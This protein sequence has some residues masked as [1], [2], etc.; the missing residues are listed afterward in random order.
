MKNLWGEPYHITLGIKNEKCKILKLMK[1]LGIQQFK[2]KDI[3]GIN[4]GLV[5]H[6]VELPLNEIKRIPKERVNKI[7]KLTKGSAAWI[8]SEGCDVCNAIL[9][10]GSFL[11][12][13]RNIQNS[14]ILYSFIAPSF[15][16][17]KSIVSALKSNNFKVKIL[18]M[19]LALKQ[20]FFDYPKKLMQLNFRID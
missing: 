16:A 11:V 18:R 5:R 9:S 2:V 14:V 10:H 17:Y 4:G 15:D 7:V 13:G 19:W 6:L 8:E 1:D 12:S 20:A 3:R